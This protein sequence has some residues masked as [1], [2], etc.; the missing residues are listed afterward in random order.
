M[1]TI[2]IILTV[3]IIIATI[4][5]HHTYVHLYHNH[6]FLRFPS[7]NFKRSFNYQSKDSETPLR[8]TKPNVPGF[9]GSHPAS[10]PV[11]D[12]N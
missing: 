7:N 6:P 12:S 11:D 3:T 4:M 9:F 1:I 8:D 2:L 10:I 5:Y